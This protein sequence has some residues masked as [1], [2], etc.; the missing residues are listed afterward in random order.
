MEYGIWKNTVETGRPQMTIWRTRIACWISKATNT[1]SEYVI[2][3][4]LH[5]KNGCTNA[6]VT[7][8]KVKQSRYRPE[9][10]LRVDRGI[11]LHP[12]DLSA[13]R[14]VWSA[15]HPGRF[16]PAKDPVPIVQEAGW[17][18]G[19]VWTFMKNLA[20]TRIRSPDRPARSQPLYR[21]SYSGPRMKPKFLKICT[22][23]TF[24]PD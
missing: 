16:T 22:A 1:H 23:V 21:L 13:R 24:V 4:L 12:R 15:S 6:H 19:P 7:I 3:L 20:P 18:P 14:N 5:C 17:A 11:A 9:Q 8:K 2:L 10:A